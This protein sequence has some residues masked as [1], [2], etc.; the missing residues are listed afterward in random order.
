MVN[1]NSVLLFNGIYGVSLS[2]L[3]FSYHFE[4]AIWLNFINLE[5][6]EYSLGNYG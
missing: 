6:N 4:T 5:K 3:I 2:L 1:L